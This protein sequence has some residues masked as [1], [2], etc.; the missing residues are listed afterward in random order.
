VH[1]RQVIVT[2]L[3]V[4]F[5]R[6][7]VQVSAFI[8]NAIASFLGTGAVSAFTNAT[9]LYQLPVALFG[10]AVSS[11]SLPSM[12]TAVAASLPD[13]MRTRL[14]SGQETI[15]A[16]VVPSMVAFLAF[17]DVMVALLLERGHFTHADTLYVW[18]ILAGSAV[19]LL[20][21]TVGRLYSAAFYALGDTRTPT[22]IA[23][24]RVV[25]VGGLGYLLALPLPRLLGIPLIWGAAGLSVSAGMAGWVEFALLR[26]ALSRR[27]GPVTIPAGIIGRAWLAAAAAASVATLLRWVVAPHWIILRGLLILGVYGT[28]YLALAQWAGILASV[29]LLRRALRRRG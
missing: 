11:A 28:L 24:L 20:A 14:T 21:T 25:L 12:S 8:D 15:A 6:G 19:G 9:Q 4:V 1:V 18:S 13:A 3:P 5:T 17:G 16:L 2:S 27:L 26:H 10:M 23:I 22:Q 29:D 7:V